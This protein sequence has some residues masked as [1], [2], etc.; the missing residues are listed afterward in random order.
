M[1]SDEKLDEFHNI[2]EEC[3]IENIENFVKNPS[4]GAINFEAATP[5]LQKLDSIL[6]PLKSYSEQIRHLPQN[7]V[8][9][10]INN[11]IEIKATLDRMEAFTLDG[12]PN[13]NRD[14]IVYTLGNNLESLFPQIALWIP[15]LAFLQGDVDKSILD[16]KNAKATLNEMLQETTEI[17]EGQK[18]QIDSI[19]QAARTAAAEVGVGH[20]TEDFAG[21]AKQNERQAVTWLWVTGLS[22]FATI[23]FAILFVSVLSIPEGATL[24]I[25][26]Q[27]TTIKF[28]TIG[29][30]ITAAIWCGRIYRAHMHQMT[31]NKQRANGLKT[32]QAFIKAAGEDEGA[33][34]A[35][36]IETT[37]SIYSIVPSGFVASEPG[38][39]NSIMEI[40][41]LVPKSS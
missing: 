24:P 27:H 33:K 22:L 2:V 15:F 19:V 8:Q 36:L 11:L 41:K 34:N 23:V 39:S 9:T 37:R 18:K 30:L 40:T 26:I 14:D 25:I 3:S 38:E 31:V 6:N 32:F 16:M 12:D 20:F 35:V 29:V 5:D 1:I 21:Q 4:W 7:V 13:A 17:I 10:T 28:V